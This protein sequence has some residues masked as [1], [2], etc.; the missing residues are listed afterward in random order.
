MNIQNHTY[1]DISIVSCWILY[2]IY[3]TYSI[4]IYKWV[5]HN[6]Y[7]RWESK[8]QLTLACVVDACEWN[9]FWTD[10]ESLNYIFKKHTNTQNLKFSLIPAI[11]RQKPT[12]P[13]SIK[14]GRA[15]LRKVHGGGNF[16]RTS[17]TQPGQQQPEQPGRHLLGWGLILSGRAI[18]KYIQCNFYYNKYKKYSTR[19]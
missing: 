11:N 9:Y 13:R 17:T 16:G 10:T 7:V 18:L 19:T 15:V 3:Y 1:I 5:P 4:H 2:T 14:I 8:L 12:I 6:C